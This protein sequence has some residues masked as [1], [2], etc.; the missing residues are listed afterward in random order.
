MI[1]QQD[2]PPTAG[3]VLAA[4]S[5]ARPVLDGREPLKWTGWALPGVS[6]V[7]CTRTVT[8]VRLPEGAPRRDSDGALNCT[9]GARLRGFPSGLRAPLSAA[10]HGC[11]TQQRVFAV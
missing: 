1:C 4:M 6:F 11:R 8:V 2:G 5:V 9:V 7:R 10:A 3:F